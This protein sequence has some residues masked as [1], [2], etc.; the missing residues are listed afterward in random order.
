LID[1]TEVEHTRLNNEGD[2]CTIVLSESVVDV[3]TPLV[4][5]SVIISRGETTSTDK[6][7]FVVTLKK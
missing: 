6:Y 2:G 3:K 4:G 5:Q 7:I 1:G